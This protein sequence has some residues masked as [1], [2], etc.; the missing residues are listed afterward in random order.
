MRDKSRHGVMI[1][2]PSVEELEYVNFK[3]LQDR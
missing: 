3:G 2:N 1:Y